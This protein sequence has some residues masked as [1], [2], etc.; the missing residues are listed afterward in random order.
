MLYS[1]FIM[2]STADLQITQGSDYNISVIVFDD[3][4]AVVN[5]T[6]YTVRGVVKNRYGDTAS[7]FD[8]SPTVTN[9]SQGQVSISLAPSVTKDFPVGK[10]HY[11]IEV[12]KD[13]I[14][15]K[16]LNGTV[17]VIPEVNS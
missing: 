4:G 3:F 5:L 10:F 2:A 17:L 15:F 14:A 16:P 11:G 12:Q 9:A 13:D 1:F 8:L 6:G 7:L